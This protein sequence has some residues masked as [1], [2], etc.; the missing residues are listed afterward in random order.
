M[1]Y[2]NNDTAAQSMHRTLKSVASKRDDAVI[3]PVQVGDPS[4][5]SLIEQFDATRI[6]MPA[7]AVIAP[8]GA[9]CSVF[10]QRVNPQQLEAAF[11]SPGQANCLKALQ[12]NKIT[13]LCVK[14]NS[15]ATI[16][17]GVRQFCEDP[18]YRNRNEIVTIQATDPAEAQFLR[19]LR[20]RTDQRTPV[21]AVLA[22]PG[23][24]VGVFGSNVTLDEL[25]KKMAA[26]G[27]CCD[28][29]N[30]KHRQANGQSTP[31]RR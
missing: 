14:P 12:D 22:P 9:I 20:V 18:L 8:N 10:P 2:K 13:V 28:D 6:P 19:Q 30:C 11:V 23:V 25:N 3:V 29:K 17:V 5:K 21:V 24:M 7:V 26:A 1:F 31:N 4:D 15:D 16:P 27:K